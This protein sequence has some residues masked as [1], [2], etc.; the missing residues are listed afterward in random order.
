MGVSYTPTQANFLWID[1]QRDCQMV[2]REMMKQGVI[3]R[4]GDFSAARHTSA[5]PPAPT[6]KTRG[7]LGPCAEYWLNDN[8]YG[9]SGYGCRSLQ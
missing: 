7:S 9:A 3:V 4:T 6:S 8:Y 1:L 2:F 5:S